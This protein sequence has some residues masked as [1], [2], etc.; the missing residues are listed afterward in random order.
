MAAA[1]GLADADA[2]M[3]GVATAART[4]AWRSDD[5]W[6]RIDA[7]V[8]RGPA[9][10]RAPARTRPSPPG[11]VLRDGEVHVTAEAPRGHRSVADVAGRG[12]WRRRSTPSSIAASLDRLAADAP[13][14]P[15]PVAGRGPHRLAELLLAGP[16]ADPR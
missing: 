5:A 10:P 4:I 14:M 16:P 8:L 2:L 15:E 1:L 13:P 3:R 11:V 12:R 7:S 9:G 6:R